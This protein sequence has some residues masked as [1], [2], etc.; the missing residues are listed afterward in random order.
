MQLLFAYIQDH[1]IEKIGGKNSYET[2]KLKVVIINYLVTS[3]T[4]N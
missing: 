4:S 2:N 3:S 1:G